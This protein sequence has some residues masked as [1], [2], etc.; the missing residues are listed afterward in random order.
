MLLCCMFVCLM[1]RRPPR[2]TRTDARFPYSRVFRSRVES[3][4]ELDGIIGPARQCEGSVRDG[5]A[6]KCRRHLGVGVEDRGRP[7]RVTPD[8][9]DASHA[10]RSEEHTS[11][12]QSPISISYA[13]FRL[14]TIT[15][16]NTHCAITPHYTQLH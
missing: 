11:E 1:I 5:R 2:S 4:D 8:A 14:K 12:I 7:A 9:E 16:T 15:Q 3:T 10:A 6:Q 13:V